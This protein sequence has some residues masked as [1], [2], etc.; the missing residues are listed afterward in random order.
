MDV[1][2]NQERFSPADVNVTFFGRIVPGVSQIDY[3]EAQDVEEVMV[4]GNRNAAGWTSGNFKY[5]G[6]I[7]LLEEEYLGL[8]L[9]AGGSILKLKPFP[10]TITK[11]KDGLVLKETL[12]NVKFTESG[13]SVQGGS[14]SALQ[15]RL[16]IK[17]FDL[18]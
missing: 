6:E 17:F 8:K 3:K 9:A 10:I 13:T 7:V 16:P 12:V 15:R 5:S 18:K 4:V 14:V 1:V 2:I 11:V